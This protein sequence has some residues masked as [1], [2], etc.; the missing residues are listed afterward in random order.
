[1]SLRKQYSILWHNAE[2]EKFG[3]VET[4]SLSARQRIAAHDVSGTW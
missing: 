2:L 1:M 3:Y 4:A